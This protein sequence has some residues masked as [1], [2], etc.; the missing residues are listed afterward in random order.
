MNNYK[1]QKNA[2]FQLQEAFWEVELLDIPE[3]ST[4]YA[5]YPRPAA[6]GF[7]RGVVKF[8]LDRTLK[9][10]LEKMGR[11]HG[12]TQHTVL[13]AGWAALLARF[14]RQDDVV[15]GMAMPLAE[16]VQPVGTGK[17]PV[18]V[19]AV[20]MRLS[21]QP[22]VAEIL[23]HA[24]MQMR[25]IRSNGHVPYDR[26][27]ELA[28]LTR[29]ASHHP[30]F[31]TMLVLGCDDERE[32][33]SDWVVNQPESGRQDA[34]C[35]L[36]LSF[37]ES[38]EG[39]AGEFSYAAALFEHE[40][41]QRLA[42]SYRLLLEDMAADETK[43]VQR[44]RIVSDAERRCVV[45]TW[46]ATNVSF[47]KG[48]CIHELFE[49]Q[50][51]CN[52]EREAVV[53]GDER[54][55]YSE[56]N[57]RANRLAH[58]LRHL[59]VKPGSCVAVCGK[60]SLEMV[61]GFLGIL[62]AGGC[63][64]PLD[65]DYP[66]DRL[67]FMMM[68]SAPVAL[69]TQE[70]EA[71]A[72][73]HDVPVLD[74]DSD[75]E[76]QPGT[77]LDPVDADD[78][79]GTPAYVIYTSGSTG[80]PKAVVVEHKNLVNLLFD[81][82][83]RFEDFHR[84]DS[85]QASMWTSFC[86]DVSV[87]EI[88][89]TLSYGG[90][91]NIV[92]DTVRSDPS[93]LLE[94]LVKT[95]VEFGYLPPFF[96]RN[97]KGLLEKTGETLPLK[98][99]LVGVE[100]LSEA[101]LYWLQSVTPG[102]TVV[103]GY[104]PTETTVF[105]TAYQD[106]A[107][108]HRNAPIGRPVAN[109]RAYVLDGQRQPVP[110]G[111]PGE[112][113]VGGAGVAR[114]YLNQSALTAERFVDD[115]FVDTP[116][117]RMYRTGDLVRWL[118]DGNLEFLGRNDFQ[119]KIRGFR[120]E[121][122]EVEA[123]LGE[124]PEVVEAAVLAREDAPGSKRLVAY[125]A[126][127]GELDVAMLRR[128]LSERMPEYM[129]PAAFVRLDRLPLTSS[130]KLDSRSLPAPRHEDFVHHAY[131]APQGELEK[132]IAGVWSELLQLDRVGRQDR[133][134]DLG[135]NSLL[136]I[137][138]VARLRDALER[139]VPLRALFL[140]ATLAEFA[141]TVAEAVP[142]QRQAIS[143]R[144][145]A[146]YETPS[147]AQQRL[148]FLAQVEGA[149]EA[150]HLA[151]GWKLRGA[152]D[153]EALRRALDGIV[154]RHESLRTTF[155]EVDGKPMQCIAAVEEAGGM[156]CVEQQAASA[157]D[158]VRLADEEATHPFD[159]EHGPLIR[160][161][162]VR[163]DA[164]RHTLLV[165]MH[166]IVS[167]GWS[168]RVFM[169]ELNT[170]YAAF[171][172]GRGDCLPPL[173][174]Q[175]ADYAVWQHTGHSDDA[176]RSG[177][178]YWKEALSGAPECLALP[179]DHPR[180]AKQC[181][182]G[183]RVGFTLD[184]AQ[185]K[186]LNALSR[187][188]GTTRFVTFLAAWAAL[189]SRLS[190]EEDIVIGTP[191]AN[192]GRA[193]LEGLIGFFVNTL[194]L[195][196]DVSNNPTVAELLHRVRDR[197][198]EAQEYQDIP[199]ERVVE[200]VNPARSRSYTPLFQVMFAWE[201]DDG[202]RIEFPGLD[203]AS[204]IEIAQRTAQFDLILTM[205]ETSAGIEGELEY[206][207]A[208]F[209][210]ETVERM[211]GHY[212]TLL[213]GMASDHARRITDIPVLSEAERQRVLRTWNATDLPHADG[214]CIHVLFEDEVRRTPDAIAVM[215]QDQTLTY[216]ELDARANRLAHRLR[217]LGAGPER[218]VAICVER[219]LD[220]VVAPLAVLKTGG[221]YVPLDP[222]SPVERLHQM[223][224]DCAPVAVLTQGTGPEALSAVDIEGMARVDLSRSLESCP[225]T[226]LDANGDEPGPQSLA[227]VIYT[228]GS[229]GKPKGVMV[230][231]RNL[232]ASTRARHA[233][234]G[235][236]GRFLLLSPIYFDSSV[237]GLFGTLTAGGTL[238]VAEQAAIRDP[239]RLGE[240]LERHRIDT[241]L[242]VPSLYANYLEFAGD[243]GRHDSLTKVIV[244][245][246]TCPP[247][248]VAK[249]AVRAP[250]ASLFN[251]YGPTEGTVWATMHACG[252]EDTGRSVPIGRPVAG[253]RVYILD[254]QERPVPIGVTG[255]LH[256]GGAGVA[257]G[258]L[259]Q[260]AMTAE[261]FVDDPFSA[262]PGARMYRTG[263]L[264]RWLPDGSIEFLG[265]NDFQ[266]KIRG[267][268]IELGEIETALLEHPAIREAAVIARQSGSGEPQLVAYAVGREDLRVETLR[269][270]LAQ[271]VPEYM[272]PRA[273]V[274]LQALPRTPNG[275]LDSVALPAPQEDAYATGEY[276][277]PRDAVETVVASIWSSL[278]G[279]ERIGRRDSFFALGGHSLLVVQVVARLREAL[280]VDVP[281]NALFASPVLADFAREVEDAAPARLPA[282]RKVVREARIPLS[283]A[284]RGLWFL[285][286]MD[287]ASA[288]YN[289]PFELSLRGPLDTRALRR[290]LDRILERH[291]A[292]RT[293]FTLLNGEPVQRVEPAEAHG[294]P[295]IECEANTPD[296]VARL[297]QE[298]E[299][300]SFDLERG[301]LIRGRL[302][303]EAE[304]LY[305]LLVTVHHLVSDG[306]SMG[307]F[308]DELSALYGAYAKEIADPLPP[309]P[310][311]YA[312]YAIWQETHLAGRMLEAQSA[313]WKA[314]L[315]GAPE[316]LTLP[317]D[318]PRPAEQ[319]YEGGTLPFTLDPSLTEALQ[320][321]STRHGTTLFMTLLA[322]WAILLSR[323]S[324]Q[325]DI[326]VGT[327][328]ANR[329]RTEIEG[330]IG[331][332]VN[333]LALRLDLSYEPSVAEFLRQVKACA[334]EA[335]GHQDIPFEQ[336]VEQVNP[337]RSLAYNPIFQ[338]MFVWGDA[339]TGD[340]A[341]PGLQAQ[342]RRQADYR[343][344]K[345]D[346]TLSVK[347]SASG[348]DAELEYATALFEP[349]TIARIADSYRTLLEGLVADD[350][351]SVSRLPLLSGA[352]R[353]QVLETWNAT[354]AS[355]PKDRCIHEW[356]EEQAQRVPSATAVACGQ[357]SLSYAEL[358]RVANRV[359]RRLR[360]LGVKPDA[361]V[362]IC[363][364][365]G[366]DMAVG[367]LGVLKAGG[368]YVPL[369]PAY[370]EERLR[371][372]VADSEPVLFLTRGA[373][374]D[375]A[376]GVPVVDLDDLPDADESNLSVDEIGLA[377]THLAYVIYT[378]GSTG[379]PKGVMIAHRNAGSLAATQIARFE[380]G[381]GSR[382][383][384]F[385]SFSFDAC[386]FEMLLAF[387]SGATLVVPASDTPLAGENL[388]RI[389]EE[390]AITHTL[391]PPAV[392][393]AIPEQETLES[394]RYLVAGGD[395]VTEDLVRRWA[396]GRHL[397]NAYGPTEI[398][399]AATMHECDAGDVGA[400]PIGRPMPNTR[401]YILDAHREPVP[402][403]VAGELYI[404]GAGVA[405]GY[406][407]R[408]KLTAERFVADPFGSDPDARL[409]RTGDLGRWRPDG[410][411]EF[412]GRNDFQVKIRGFRIELGEI[413]ARLRAC[414]GVQEAVV[415]AREDVP[416]DKRLVAYYV[417]DENIQVEALRGDLSGHLPGYMVPAAFVRMETFPL[418]P[419][420][421]LDRKGL[422]APEG[423]AYGSRAYEA[424]RGECEAVLAEI[425][426]TL[427]H[428]ER[429]GRHDD[430]FQLGGHSLLT[431]K[432][433][434]RL[435]ARL[436]VDVPVS[437]LFARPTLAEF[438]GYVAEA[439][440]SA[441]P[442]VTPAE[443]GA[444]SPASFAQRRQWFLAQMDG[445][446]TA[447]HVPY[448][449]KLRGRLDTQALRRALDRIVARHESLRTTFVQ[450][451][452]EPVQRIASAED[453]RFALVGETA[454]GPEAVARLAQHETM[455]RFDLEQ[456]PLIRGLLICEADDRYTL[457]VTMHHII[458][459]GW[460]MGVFVGE[461]EALYSAYAKGQSDPLAPLELHYADYAIWQ[462]KW[463]S[464]A[465][466]EKQE[467]YW[468][469]SL[470]GAPELIAL[471]TDHPRPPEQSYA[472]DHVPVVVDETLTKS[473]KDLSQRHGSTPFMTLLAGW[474]AL[475]SRL[476]GQEDLVVGTPTANRG[477]AEI[478][479]L[480]GF[481]VNTLA[482]RMDLTG[483]PTVGQ[484]L[485]RVRTCSL[486]AQENQNIPFEQVVERVN[487]TR[488]IAHTPLFQVVFSWE[489]DDAM[490]PRL[491]G[492]D[493]E[494]MDGANYKVA[495]FDLTLSL[496]ESNGRIEGALEYATALFERETIERIA[497][498]YQAMLK[499]M[500]ADAARPVGAIPILAEAEQNLVLRTWNATALPSAS[501]C[502]VH[503]LFEEQAAR[504]PD[505]TAVVFE[506]T[507]LTYSEF[508]RSANRLAHRLRSMGVG[509]D[510]R[511]AICMER[512]L[513]MLVALMGILKAGGAY[514]AMDPTYP[515]ERLRHIL[516]DSAPMAL[517]TH[518][519]L[520]EGVGDVLDD[521][522]PVLDLARTFE[523]QPDTNP[524]AADV[525]L[526]PANLAYLIYTSGSTGTPKGVMVEHRS[527]VNL[528]ADWRHRFEDYGRDGSLQASLWTSFS[529]DVSVFE[530][531]TPLTAGAT[532]HVVP[533]AIRGE[534]T[535]LFDWFVQHRI[536][537]AYLPPF[538]VRQMDELMENAGEA[539]PFDYLLVGVEPL[540]EAQLHRMQS[541]RPGAGIRIV[542]GY[543]PT[544]TTVFST[545][546]QD[547]KDVHR[548]AP[549]GR[550][551]GNTQTYILDAHRQPV[552]VGVVGELFI[553]GAGLARGYMNLPELTAERFLRDPFSEEP[554]ARMY[555][556]G[557]L[558][559][560]M[561]DGNIEFLGRNDHQVKIRGFR[562][563]LGE[564][565]TALIEHPDI[566]EAV[567]IAREDAAGDRALVAYYVGAGG[568]AAD[569]LRTHLSERL[570]KHMIPMAFVGMEALPLL[571]NGKLDQR[572]LPAPD[573]APVRS[574]SDFVAPRNEH[575]ARIAAIWSEVL[576]IPDIGIDDNFFDLGGESFKAFR[577]IGRIGD[578]M[579]VTE[580]FK[581]PTV[582]Q[583]AERISG[584][585]S[586][587]ED[588]LHELSRPV[589][590]KEK[591]F[592]LVCI[593][594]PAGGPISYQ[595]LAKE[596]PRGC[597]VLG[598]EMPGH[599]FGRREEQPLPID[600]LAR[601]CAEEIERKVEGPIAIYGHCAGG[602]LTIALAA[603]L[604]KRNIDITR[605]FIGGHFPT[606]HLPG[607]LLAFLRRILP[608]HKWAS[609]R[610]A[611]DILKSFGFF[612]EINDPEQR[613]FVMANFV[614][615][616]Q[617]IEDYYTELYAAPYRKL[618]TPLTCVIGE[619]DRATELYEER[620]LEWTYFSESVDVALIPKAGHYFIKHQADDLAEIIEDAV[621]EGRDAP[622]AS[623]ES[624]AETPVEETPAVAAEPVKR[625]SL[626]TFF[627]VAI[628][629]IISVIGSTLT[630]FALGVWVYQKTGLV[631][632][633]AMMMVFV[634]V[635]AIALAPVAGTL[636]D[637]IDRKKI[638]IASNCLAG[639]S[640]MA[641]AALIWTGTL[642]IWQVYVLAGLTAIANAFR[643][644]A[645]TAMITQIV[646][647]RYYGKANGFV[648]IGTGMGTFIGPA[649]AGALM[650]L[651]GLKG[652]VIT[653]FT[654]FLVAI[655]TLLY[656]RFPN[657][658]FGRR[659]EPFFREMIGGW[660]YIIKRH[661][662]VAMIVMVT[663][664]NYFVGLI[665]SLITPLVLVSGNPE[666]LGIV[667]ASNGAGILIGS[668]LM[669][670]WGG[671]E[672]RINGIL[673]STL[674]AGVCIA[675]AGLSPDMSVQATGMFG[676]GF[677]LAL[678]NAHW[679]S[680]VQ[681]KVGME[682]QGRVMATNFMLMEAMVPL[683][684]LSAG[685]LADKVF[686]PLM[687][688]GGAWV[689]V[690][691][692]FIGSGPGRGIG[693]VLVLSGLFVALCAI[694]AYLYRP[695]RCLEDILPDARA[696]EVIEADKD[697][698]Q[699]K[700][701]LALDSVG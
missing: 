616:H 99:L 470:A 602:A 90:T 661:S 419:N 185:A 274:R 455:A 300:A 30:L 591:T 50:A 5:D 515:E 686:G 215:H 495:K 501:D 222:A 238:V 494:L 617:E 519:A 70:G 447:Y 569:T 45:E 571:P 611:F 319:R 317:T 413:E 600:E 343:I 478:E 331:Y 196:V 326:V 461:L 33:S 335:Q 632:T 162:L 171:M 49:Q 414:D 579:G 208:L 302:V 184:T 371:Y 514:V 462:R 153:A 46:N 178:D 264:G 52:P 643:L 117:A 100:P 71:S 580:L 670:L 606:P 605:M 105:C 262:E 148:W 301:P 676:F 294:F 318:H 387:C 490:H 370:P 59:C 422:P 683:G 608:I 388:V 120:V 599:D 177:E 364:E 251:E 315:A 145:R 647:K 434:S 420:G 590:A 313:Y 675:I 322:A 562:I 697:K 671:T 439:T 256:I 537:S 230:E 357:A 97:L 695:I 565:E 303:H 86:F 237:A 75:F 132:T 493:T 628:G 35:D 336:I 531:F 198:L 667:M 346:L 26:V 402:V 37:R 645:Y 622:E 475:L 128:Y 652:I 506:D 476:S 484:L 266:V 556:T 594:F 8:T 290:A 685:P 130:G 142:T 280:Q 210:R 456:G 121:L 19:L 106:I 221:A 639:F 308:A 286:Q 655:S 509:P 229:T 7:D 81:W 641:A 139:D 164:D 257:R 234:Y 312:D 314:K 373:H 477:R 246:E 510:A 528:I 209:E 375:V 192:R 74:L 122:G 673:A 516:V 325:E 9:V 441:L 271:R 21:G 351:R 195:R 149:S 359:A 665:E 248:L 403:G 338:V 471:P 393:A 64:V 23:D 543:G 182:A 653:D 469:A 463:M 212:Q 610:S 502:C 538:F 526:G 546:Y 88:F 73:A 365:R 411:I 435:R 168:M 498:Y 113:Y 378:S 409:Y 636:A 558:A 457:L 260:P 14:S 492:V 468:E 574:E 446:A 134:L 694:A 1:N 79:S 154:A 593:P 674:L 508:N 231:H 127:T 416:G 358:N 255:Q 186:A 6:L 277:A 601:R 245:G 487:P 27:V 572:A 344:S 56:L 48:W 620:H 124:H 637:R 658:L 288:A 443:R 442:E 216:A 22:T 450:I 564:I 389:V 567:V 350:Q 111:V 285:A 479:G 488:S 272:V 512:G 499:G 545:S 421:K 41:V 65:P 480:I 165:T 355:Y 236:V 651:I 619:M 253:A 609:Q 40:T 394:I 627:T 525:G 267:F 464:G 125:C 167:D 412:L 47:P 426:T 678:V 170:L 150:Y 61:V 395:V 433:M 87:F 385:A 13:L 404:G 444:Q 552:P 173:E 38:E 633:Y 161:R 430:F 497:G 157:E 541:S 180:P 320:D 467:A 568:L 69:L 160:A 656:V 34:H 181:Y 172:D 114:G 141:G 10:A 553:G 207:T 360:A 199:F 241:L 401:I 78:A 112:L 31:Q 386:V 131:E 517:L 291:E 449:L 353:R 399:V 242:C 692:S 297:A 405:R 190:G 15:I 559:R 63:Y 530:L 119:V 43:C 140:D 397:I 550:P 376:G 448:G 174:V 36:V 95:R 44:L 380:P 67:R 575:E 560:W 226:P 548:N 511:V 542:N 570:P 592:T 94:W 425:W 612:D 249:S 687:D 329:G 666:A 323:F 108:R 193:E 377:P 522:L 532:V 598:L 11:G 305:T 649:L 244:A 582:R 104:G 440:P 147:F 535:R 348:L 217:A 369:D 585:R 489:N 557:D 584:G 684:Y 507:N 17:S 201:D 681:T 83:A 287:G 307:V 356:F 133:F 91:L 561:P 383:L 682:L 4:I 176:L 573:L 84:A 191:S 20:R 39:V 689:P 57:V 432:V 474:V 188:Q 296:D 635:P 668:A 614:R 625:P 690:L 223:L 607:K 578:G 547:M 379:K 187:E 146:A 330:L 529:F 604:E 540:L 284:Q 406:L 279:V 29:N 292:L 269:S 452:G 396:R 282:V 16:R 696:D 103:N 623:S 218:A 60:R 129:V 289:I 699:E 183:A 232:V 169:R 107:D 659:E 460:S 691:G 618:K 327:P 523:D 324:G 549:I 206:A 295:L 228:S 381:P 458:S 25:A 151:F 270:H 349:E 630:S 481:F 427:L 646:P 347:P 644:P 219:S 101:D 642:Q 143:A 701:D 109:T 438:A 662:L 102:L 268:R 482:L 118:P 179:L 418:S 276:E 621:V 629:E 334:L 453:S 166:H 554:G 473:L 202:L 76:E 424:P 32:E 123:C 77:N 648:Q 352:V 138:V 521:T 158:V 398:T 583:L 634:I 136:S 367:V 500:A 527:V 333:T 472:G 486:R 341:F 503:E 137:Q 254:A 12:V 96:V 72:W 189:M 555:R 445:A 115:P 197:A 417:G 415:L 391:L 504:T 483:D 211:I 428:V 368:A 110:V 657:T 259:H 247:A 213:A 551:V 155:V 144:V 337:T 524:S 363:V 220:M 680:T 587:S 205:R 640:T 451:D 588:L 258:Y 203:D 631:S 243:A 660:H 18:D 316:L 581:Y 672:R 328:T 42:D 283:F 626:A 252:E 28:G 454:V 407:N 408:P 265:R 24:K 354:E 126:G 275:K 311:Q 306:W 664:A 677:A 536:G 563:E 384:Q 2:S 679:I 85:F 55:T 650:G 465:Y 239:S 204:P 613:D 544:E 663:I 224:D 116:D 62:K 93:A 135:G 382:V 342:V 374:P 66:E 53:F 577:V 513:E 518:G 534:P 340:L 533:D 235:D 566:R 362:A 68:N 89:A 400:P 669:S 310:V 273:Y 250:R 436:G 437:A 82:K 214:S 586:D 361:R 638:M 698:L 159:L 163:E 615:E 293:T 51:A 261:R 597:T 309:L 595:A 624:V 429:V 520:P 263:D 321:L 58:R 200:R 225:D 156:A 589:P 603:E 332:F 298:E 339:G 299:A 505:A 700:A 423:D 693:L 390:T 345:F 496:R 688:K 80:T 459:D 233:A 194:A 431:V 366:I 304:E 281:L 576:G 485:D 466:L 392:L 596:M 240:V 152:L 175:Y 227:Y 539:L 3:I 372:I 654:T 278:L 98:H 54:L 92:P 410:V 491:P